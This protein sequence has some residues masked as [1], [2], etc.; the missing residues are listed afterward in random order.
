MVLGT[1]ALAPSATGET[2]VGESGREPAERPEL[3]TRHARQAIRLPRQTETSRGG[4]RLAMTP[5]VVP[6]STDPL[7][8][9][10]RMMPSGS[11]GLLGARGRWPSD[12]VNAR[13][14]RVLL[15]AH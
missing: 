9:F 4:E 6:V 14:G 15:P 1:P 2:G 13:P 5:T 12:V 3:R 7:A 8:S 10:T 11:W